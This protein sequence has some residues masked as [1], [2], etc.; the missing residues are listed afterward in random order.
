MLSVE[1]VAKVVGAFGLDG[2]SMPERTRVPYSSNITCIS[3]PRVRVHGPMS[4]P[5]IA[6]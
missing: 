2:D 1:T 6:G 5:E 4:E 3:F